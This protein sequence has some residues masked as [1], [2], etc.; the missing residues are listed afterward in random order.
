M[1]SNSTAQLFSTH[2]SA[3]RT[4][5]S[6]TPPT[7]LYSDNHLLVVN[8]PPGWH[9]VPNKSLEDDEDDA[10]IN[11]NSKCLLTC[12]QAEKLGG[13]SQNNFLL[14]IHRIDQPCSGLTMFAKTS[15]AAS[16]IAKVWKQ[17]KVV[18]T[19]L[20]LIDPGNL[21]SLRRNSQRVEEAADQQ[22][23]CAT[24]GDG[25]DGEIR[26]DEQGWW[27]L[28]GYLHNRKKRPRQI[29]NDGLPHGPTGWS[30]VITQ[31]EPKQGKSKLVL[32][33]WRRLVGAMN[34]NVVQIQS[35]DGARHL[36]RALLAQIGGCPIVGDARYG[37]KHHKPTSVHD[38]YTVGLHA[39]TILLPD[40]LQLGTTEQRFFEAPIPASWLGVSMR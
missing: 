21:D 13:G 36:I 11:D 33:Y 4:A 17:K 40:S 29:T 7:V 27:K 35:T 5:S 16:R 34:N 15:K 6:L 38:Q 25:A 32:A 19:Y 18:K 14:P 39:H 10:S 26:K 22:A 1:K 28:E 12:L 9:V 8:K 31:E 3:A 24:A 37:P 30:V 20:C 23:L 2:A